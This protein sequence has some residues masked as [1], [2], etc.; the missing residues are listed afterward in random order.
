MSRCYQ[1][2]RQG[3][4][5]SESTVKIADGTRLGGVVK[6]VHDDEDE[7]DDDARESGTG[8]SAEPSA[9]NT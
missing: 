9:V 6:V 4:L 1:P 5:R 8:S 2:V 3:P 7:R